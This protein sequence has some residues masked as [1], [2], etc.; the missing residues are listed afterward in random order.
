MSVSPTHMQ[1][2]LH[3]NLGCN[4]HYQELA[5]VVSTGGSAHVQ[6]MPAGKVAMSPAWISTGVPP[7]RA[8]MGAAFAYVV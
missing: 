5:A 2:K 6:D 7:V 3:V 1:Q 4:M 8:S